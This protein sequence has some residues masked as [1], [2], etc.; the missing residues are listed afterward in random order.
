MYFQGNFIDYS[1]KYILE[2]SIKAQIGF[3]NKAKMEGIVLANRILSE[4]KGLRTEKGKGVGSCLVLRHDDLKPRYYKMNLK[5]REV[6][7]KECAKII[8]RGYL[9]KEEADLVNSLR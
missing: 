8:E 9:L 6:A 3:N 5:A 2:K 4:E 1:R 7:D